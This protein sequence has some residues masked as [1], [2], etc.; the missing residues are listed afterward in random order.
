MATAAT[1]TATVTVTITATNDAPAAADD[2][3]TTAED[4]AVTIAVLANDSD[5]DGDTLVVGSVG[6]ALHG[7]AVI[8]PDGTVTYTPAANYNGTDSFSY[9]I[10]DG[11]GGTATANRY[12]DDHGDERRPGGGG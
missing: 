2:A 4:T 3:A 10:G 6:A 9:T 11:H 5:L 1:A 8:N 7:G 12:R